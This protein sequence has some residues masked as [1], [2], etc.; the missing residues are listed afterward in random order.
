MGHSCGYCKYAIPIRAFGRCVSSSQPWDVFFAD[1]VIHKSLSIP[2][3]QYNNWPNVPL[4][5]FHFFGSLFQIS[6]GTWLIWQDSLNYPSF[7]K[8]QTM[9]MYVNF[10]WFPVKKMHRLGWSNNDPCVSYD[11]QLLQ[12]SVKPLF[13]VCQL[14]KDLLSNFMEISRMD[15]QKAMDHFGKAY[16]C[17]WN[18]DVEWND[19]YIKLQ[20]YKL[21]WEGCQSKPCHLYR[22]TWNARYMGQWDSNAINGYG[23]YMGKD[24]REWLGRVQV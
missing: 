20:W 4:N 2:D 8:H 13:H 16:L 9:Q 6:I 24:G 5:Q 11:K 23:H 14:W 7:W 17:V 3:W 15:T 22:Y 18:Y 12:S 1:W 19:I 21:G 10:G